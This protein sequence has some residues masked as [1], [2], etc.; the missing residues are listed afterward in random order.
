MPPSFPYGGYENLLLTFVSPSLIDLTGSKEGVNV[1]IHEIAHSWTGNTV[2][3]G[4]WS[5]LWP[6]EGFTVFMERKALYSLFGEDYWKIE[7]INGNS[8]VNHDYQNFSQVKH[9]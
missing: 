4:N 3:C 6:N 7:A 1:A 9:F 8:T 5:N 2:T